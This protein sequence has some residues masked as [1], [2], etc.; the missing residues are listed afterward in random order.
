MVSIDM[1]NPNAGNDFAK[2][3]VHPESR[4]KIKQFDTLRPQPC[5]GKEHQFLLF[6][7]RQQ[8]RRRLDYLKF[9][10]GGK[11][12]V[13]YGMALIALQVAD[14]STPVKMVSANH[15]FDPGTGLVT[16]IRSPLPVEPLVA[17]PKPEASPASP[18]RP[19]FQGAGLGGALRKF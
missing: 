4:F 9:A 13:L 11:L 1:L 12:D 2:W 14:G 10:P 15:Q 8:F 17:N 16:E 19:P 3:A 6:F 18:S 7:R 5:G